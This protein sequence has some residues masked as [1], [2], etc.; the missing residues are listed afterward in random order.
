MGR[1]KDGMLHAGLVD[2]LLDLELHLRQ[3]LCFTLSVSS[4]RMGVHD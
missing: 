2:V 4:T 3:Y 1:Y